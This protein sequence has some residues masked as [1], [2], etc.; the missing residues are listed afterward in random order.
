MAS[1]QNVALEAAR[2]NPMD[3]TEDQLIS[4]IKNEIDTPLSM[5]STN[6]AQ[7]DHY[8]SNAEGLTLNGDYYPI[9]GNNLK[10]VYHDVIKRLRDR[11][12]RDLFRNY[13]LLPENEAMKKKKKMIKDVIC[14]VTGIPCPMDV[15]GGKKRIRSKSRRKKSSGRKSHRKKKSHKKRK[16]KRSK[17]K[18]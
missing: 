14:E 16:T 6:D 13:D 12:A 11:G 15:S 5:S 7:L 18:H 9:S 2:R 10:T 8:L 1:M 3:I 17:L 4:K